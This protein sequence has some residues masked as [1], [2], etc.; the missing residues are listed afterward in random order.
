METIDCILNRRSIRKY[1][2]E[3]ITKEQVNT[4][5]KA[6]MYAPTARNMQPWHFVYTCDKAQL[7]KLSEIHPYGKMLRNASLAVLTC[8]DLE[9]DKTESYLVQNCSAAT[10]NI[11]L[12]AHALGLGAVW[13][14]VHP[15][16]ERM[17]PI[18]E[19]FELPKNILPISLISIGYPAEE[20][21][22]PERYDLN[23]IHEGQW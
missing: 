14:G 11:L 1:K 18:A 15:R 6:A 22:F 9:I 10:Q 16:E 8:G 7:I 3:P 4:L 19:Y 17:K 21:K 20:P 13:L 12:A 2:D 5:F 23:K